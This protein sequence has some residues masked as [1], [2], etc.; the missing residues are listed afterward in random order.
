MC[1]IRST[2]Q[3]QPIFNIEIN[4]EIQRLSRKPVVLREHAIDLV[5]NRLGL[6][7]FERLCFS[8]LSALAS[9]M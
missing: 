7:D 9:V 2:P 3:P 6:L 1:K 8:S 5:D 4:N